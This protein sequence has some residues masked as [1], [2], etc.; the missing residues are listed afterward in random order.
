M[1]AIVP[2]ATGLQLSR[3]RRAE[4]RAGGDLVL[5]VVTDTGIDVLGG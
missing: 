4:E 3:G 1:N 5:A 2:A